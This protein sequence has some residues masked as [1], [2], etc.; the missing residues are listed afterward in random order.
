MPRKEADPAPRRLFVT[1]GAGYI[2]SHVVLRLLELGHEVLVFD[3]LS[4]GR[5][6][7]GIGGDFYFGDL[8]DPAALRQALARGSFDAVLHFAASTDVGESQRWPLA[9]HRNNA[10]NSLA[11]LEAC[12]EAGISRLIFSSTAAVYGDSAEGVLRESAPLCPISPYGASKLAAERMIEDLAAG[13]DQRFVTLRYFNVAGTDPAGRAGPLSDQAEHLITALCRTILGRQEGF[14]IN[15]DDYPTPDGTCERDFIH[16]LDLVEAH[17][18][19]LDRLLAGGR[20]LT[21]NC[22][23]GHGTSVAEVVAVARQV[24]GVAFPVTVGPRRPGDT[25][26]AIADCGLIKDKLGWQPRHDDLAAM[27]ETALA[28]EKVKAERLAAARPPPLHQI[29]SPVGG[30]QAATGKA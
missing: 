2:G 24:S 4:T 10:A 1:G 11:L 20:S 22:G 13:S 7:P 14:V 8:G 27:I 30:R 28:W 17:I 6:L 12:R 26:R 25:V 18:A 16:V 21:L 15:G 3:N 29:K 5:R 9:Y 23:Y 19:A